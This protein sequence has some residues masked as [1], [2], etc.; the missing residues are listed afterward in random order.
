[1]YNGNK[2]KELLAEQGRSNKDLLEYLGVSYNSSITQL[3]N[4]N[5]SVRKIEKIAD[6]FGVSI[7]TFFIRDTSDN[8]KEVT[9]KDIKSLENKILYLEKLLKEKERNIQLLEK[10][11]E[12]LSGTLSGQNNVNK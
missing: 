12:L 9:D 7:D 3:T 10:L 5:P 2:I 6:F 1:M 4:G 11:N 8:N